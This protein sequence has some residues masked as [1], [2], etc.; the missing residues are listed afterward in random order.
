MINAGELATF[1]GV[2]GKIEGQYN[3][4]NTILIIKEDFNEYNPCHCRK[5]KGKIL[6]AGYR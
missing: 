1:S 4:K 2:Y 5:A 3:G 6:E